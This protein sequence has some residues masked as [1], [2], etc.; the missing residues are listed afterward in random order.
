MHMHRVWV[1]VVGA[2][3][4]AVNYLPWTWYGS[5]W[6][7]HSVQLSG[8]E[9]M[10]LVCGTHHDPAL[11]HQAIPCLAI[12]LSIY[13]SKLRGSV[14]TTITWGGTCTCA[15]RAP[16][17]DKTV[18]QLCITQPIDSTP[19]VHHDIVSRMAN[20]PRWYCLQKPSTFVSPP[21]APCT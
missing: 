17:L 2:L 4:T 19:Q 3:P 18:L 7:Q 6:D 11:C 9:A 8:A 21:R 1:S 12:Y 10:H 20:I 15:V 13:T 5:G 14:A 16:A